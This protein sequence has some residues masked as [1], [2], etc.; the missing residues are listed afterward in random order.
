MKFFKELRRRN[1]IRAAISYLVASWLILQVAAIVFP[2]FKIDLG[3]QRIIFIILAIGFPFWM[4]FAYLYNWTPEGFVRTG[5]PDE[6]VEENYGG[7]KLNKIIIAGLSLAVVL[8]LVDRVF[9]LSGEIMQS[10]ADPITIA[11]L[12]FNQ[13][14]PDESS[15]FFT[16]GVHTDIMSK[17]AGIHNFRISAKSSVMAYKDFDGTLSEIGTRLKARYVMDGSVRRLDKHVRITTN[18]LD[19]ESGK[20]IWSETYDGVLENVFELQASIATDI[21][22]K[23]RANLSKDEKQ[24]LSTIPTDNIDAYDLFLKAQ[25]IINDPRQTLE[26]IEQAIGFLKEAVE[27]DKKFYKAWALLAQANSEKYQ[28]LNRL[29]GNESEKS[30]TLKQVDEAIEQAKK[31]APNNWEVLSVEGFYQMNIKG[32]MIKALQSFERVVEENPSAIT[33]RIELAKIYIGMNEVDKSISHLEAAFELVQTNGLVSYFLSYAYEFNREF[34]KMVPLLERLATLYPE[35]KHYGVDAAYYQFLNDGSI[36]SFNKFQE[37]LKI[38][39]ADNPWDERALQNMEMVVAMFNNETEL[40]FEKWKG[41]NASHIKDHGNW[42]CPLVANDN[43]N[44]ARI[45]A[46]EKHN[47]QAD[48]ILD[49][50]SEIV[51]KPINPNT[52]CTFNPE[53]YLPKL[54]FLKGDTVKARKAF[55]A[56]VPEV[57]NNDLFPLG[58]VERSV[59]VQAADL[60]YPEQVYHYYDIAVK[61]AASISSFESICADPWTYPNLIKDPRF[62]K[63]IRDDGRFVKFLELHGFLKKYSV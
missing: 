33:S 60:I 25:F 26:N 58:S 35:Q 37:K 11:V 55:D 32:D 15:A 13:E 7:K 40:Y 21:A 18:L 47:H 19:T 5:P 9:N 31:L 43:L 10:D 44:H 41:K 52:V 3:V 20:T 27:L 30:A 42:M 51:L 54:A 4:V 14:S 48:L 50:V 24:E 56:V 12:P 62:V 16:S 8:L 39:N 49:E 17:L 38:T 46:N 59:L 23:L 45:L 1:V 28:R 53:V 36:E 29:E 57:L 34:D 61:N 2:M 63:E 6:A 22:Q